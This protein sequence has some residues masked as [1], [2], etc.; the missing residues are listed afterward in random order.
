MAVG[1]TGPSVTFAE[2]ASL[3]AYGFYVGDDVSRAYYSGRGT[4]V[5][6]GGNI[7]TNNGYDWIIEEVTTLP[8]TVTE[9]GYAT[10]FAPVEVTVPEGTVTAHIFHLTAFHTPHPCGALP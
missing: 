5:D 2:G 3:G 10:L 7:A 4:Y 1:T 6:A 8:V 9:A